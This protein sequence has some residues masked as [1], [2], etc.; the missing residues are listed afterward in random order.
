M[1]FSFS[2]FL[3]GWWMVKQ[4]WMSNG[5]SYQKPS[6]SVNPAQVYPKPSISVG[7]SGILTTG[8]SAN[9]SC[10]SE[11]NPH[12][13]FYLYKQGVSLLLKA[14]NIKAS[15][16]VFSFTNAQQSDGGIYWCAYCSRSNSYKQCSDFSDNIH[17]NVTDSSL[18]TPSISV[19][20][21][22]HLALNSDV[23]IEC[24][25]PENGL[26][27]SLYKASH[28]ITSQMSDPSRNTTNFALSMKR[29]EDAGNYTCQY[30]QRDNPFVW[31]EPSTPVELIVTER[32]MI[33]I[34]AGCA[35]GFLL[36]ILLLL[37]AF[38]LYRK[39]RKG[40]KISERSRVINM[41][42]G[43]D[44]KAVYDEVSYGADTDGVVY[45]VLNQDS[46]KIKRTTDSNSPPEPC[47][48]ASVSVDTNREGH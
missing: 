27:F 1:R 36:V 22:R 21:R 28:L 24:E 9:I 11:N 13:D 6:I 48:Y 39:K 43:A 2:V 23:I 8:G 20:P 31:S 35:A 12:T 15:E 4:S 14:E 26:N 29:L 42:L 34:W 41:P 47:V 19:R 18:R 25:G 3:L 16:A 46:L 10:N 17:I 5:Q 40:P 30:H 7:L 33:T 37:L 38:I 45:A 44:A 32:S